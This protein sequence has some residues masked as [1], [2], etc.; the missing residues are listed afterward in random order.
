MVLR[1]RKRPGMEEEDVL[2]VPGESQAPLPDPY[3]DD[4]VVSAATACNLHM[5]PKIVCQVL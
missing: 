3:D 1:V 2:H 5:C 4:D